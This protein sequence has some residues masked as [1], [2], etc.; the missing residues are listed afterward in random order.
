LAFSLYFTS[1]GIFETQSEVR[2]SQLGMFLVSEILTDSEEANSGG[3]KDHPHRLSTRTL[4]LQM[5]WV[6]LGG[7]TL[8][9][10][11]ITCSGL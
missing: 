7:A 5:L 3:L 10:E 8:L 1:Q 9:K 4:G 6:A 2:S 11:D